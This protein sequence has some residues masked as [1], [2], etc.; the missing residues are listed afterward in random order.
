MN[1]AALIKD[2]FK[3]GCRPLSIEEFVLKFG[4]LSHEEFNKIS[5]IIIL[6]EDGI[7]RRK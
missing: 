2:Y 3:I 6:C 7:I 5:D 1:K 4:H